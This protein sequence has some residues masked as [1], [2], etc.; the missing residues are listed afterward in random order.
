MKGS[1][2]LLSKVSKSFLC[3]HNVNAEV[4]RSLSD[5]KNTLTEELTKLS[6][7]TLASLRRPKKHAKMCAE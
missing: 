5:N 3:L 7:E 4:A 6:D 2:K 1:F